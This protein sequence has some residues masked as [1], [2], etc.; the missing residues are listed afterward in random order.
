METRGEHPGAAAEATPV[1]AT[2]P[3][4]DAATP[5]GGT[6]TIVTA[7]AEMAADR[8]DKPFVRFRE[9]D[10]TYAAFE[11]RTR[12]LASGLRRHAVAAL[13]RPPEPSAA[14]ARHRTATDVPRH[15]VA[16]AREGGPRVVPTLLPN[17]ADAAVFWF[18]ANRA[19]A[20]WAPLN[21]E[22]R[23]PGLAH[24]INL[25]GSRDLVVDDSLL[26]AVLE[27]GDHLEHVERLI[28]RSIASDGAPPLGGSLSGGTRSFATL[29]LQALEIDDDGV[30]PAP[31]P[32]AAAPSLLIYT[33]GTTGVSKACELSHRYVLGHAHLLSRSA[34]MRADDVLFC[35]YPIFHWDATIGTIAPALWLGATAVVTERFSVSRFWADVRRYGVTIF[36]FM[37]ATLTFIYK[38][39]RRPDD[40]DNPAR[41]G[42]GVPM[43]AFKDDFEERFGVTLV[44]GYGS[45]EGGIMVWQEPGESFPAGSCGRALP[46]FRLRIVDAADRPLPA[47]E[48]GEI[49]ARPTRDADR[50]LMLTGYYR[51]PKLNREVFRGGWFH[52]GDLGR[53]DVRGNLYFEGRMK[54]AI[55]RRGENISAY[56]I[57]QV[58]EAH[59]AVL[60][61]AAYGVPSE[62][63]EED[64]AV[65]VALRPGCELSADEL[66]DHCRG[67]MARYM[68]PVFVR[69]LDALPKTPTEKVEKATLRKW[70]LRALAARGGSGGDR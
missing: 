5:R 15:A 23:G 42:W 11:A 60:E 4:T 55:R 46:E 35:P 48:I 62:Y 38:R 7:L 54:D 36:D 51:M 30:P 8:P 43:P 40:A 63:T 17:C 33:S 26:D 49:V 58:V 37:G 24:A 68:V 65:S 69:F 31:Q 34:G 16:K 10:L 6:A 66:L 21:T 3:G 67:R 52:T 50:H 61:A 59:P 14:G 2:P 56:E 27:I 70:H 64:V 19:G 22:F 53:L 41:L 44:E 45:T 25:T 47:G 29:P 20:V 1:A 12:S 57:E 9:A 13:G 28:V 18:A 39:E 32:A